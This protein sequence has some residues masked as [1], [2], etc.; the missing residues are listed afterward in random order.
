MPCVRAE[1]ISRHR[2]ARIIE[3]TVEAGSLSERQDN[4]AQGMVILE[5]EIQ[6]LTV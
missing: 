1:F 2:N 5:V 3:P 4:S 6:T